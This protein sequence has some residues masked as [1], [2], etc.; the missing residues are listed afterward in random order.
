M[1]MT[2]TDEVLQDNVAMVLARA[3]AAANKQ[4]VRWAWILSDR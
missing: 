2:L 1:S 3:V 4:R